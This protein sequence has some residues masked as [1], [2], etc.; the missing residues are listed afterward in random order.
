MKITEQAK[1]DEKV[2]A[3]NDLITWTKR[4]LINVEHGF[5]VSQG[6]RYGKALTI[7]D[8]TLEPNIKNDE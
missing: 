4:Y 3:I 5:S 1:V 6:Y 7:Y 8:L 2:K